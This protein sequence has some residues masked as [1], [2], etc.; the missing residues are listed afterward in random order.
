MGDRKHRPADEKEDLSIIH[1][2]GN[3]FADLG[4]PHAE[5]RHAK[6][7]LAL[8]IREIV[9][10]SGMN[11][12]DAAK[13]VGIAASDLSNI[14]RGRVTNFSSDRLF[15]VLNVLGNDVEITIRPNRAARG[16][17]FVSTSADPLVSVPR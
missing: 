16:S 7:Q 12:R 11:Q 4:L 17:V 14:M 9:E 3:T 1:G 10:E 13:K 2:T 5:E 8:S 15:A 6:N